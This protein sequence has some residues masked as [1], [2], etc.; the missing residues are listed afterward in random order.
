MEQLVSS[1]CNFFLLL[2]LL[3]CHPLLFFSSYLLLHLSLLSLPLSSSPFS[4]V[5]SLLSPLPSLTL[6]LFLDTCTFKI[7]KS[8]TG[9]ATSSR[10]PHSG[11][12]QQRRKLTYWTDSHGLLISRDSAL[13]RCGGERGGKR[14][15]EW[16]RG[17]RERGENG[18]GEER[19]NK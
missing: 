9:F 15:R 11:A 10:H 13:L 19:E 18:K 5:P 6:F 16:E 3:S 17:G 2:S 8:A 14:G 1:K 7:A 4:S 12:L